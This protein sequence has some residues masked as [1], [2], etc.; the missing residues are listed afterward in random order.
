MT[1][2]INAPKG[3]LTGGGNHVS[4]ICVAGVLLFSPLALTNS[5]AAPGW[6]M[7]P[8]KATPELRQSLSR[9]NLTAGRYVQ[10]TAGS[11]SAEEGRR[12]F[13]RVMGR[14]FPDSVSWLL[15]KPKGNSAKSVPLVVF[16]PGAGELGDDLTRQFHQHAIFERVTS[17]D[18]QS[19]HPC[20]LL[21]L[22]PAPM[23]S[24]YLD[25][26]PGEPSAL[27]DLL[28]GAISAMAST[29]SSPS[30]DKTRIY[31]T[32]LSLG[33]EGVYGLA[34]AFP[35]FF[36][37][38]MPVAAAPP[39]VHYLPKDKPLRFWHFYNDGDYAGRGLDAGVLDD[40]RE[41]I[42]ASGGEFRIGIY[43]AS[44]HNAWDAAWRE[45]AAW[46]WMFAQQSGKKP[47]D[48]VKV[49][50]GRR[51]APADTTSSRPVCTASCPGRDEKSAPERAADG[52]EG[53]AYVSEKPVG[54][55]A[56]LQVEYPNGISGRLLVKTGF[57]DGRNRLMRGRVVT[58]VDGKSWNPCGHVSRETG[59]CS[60][61]L[62]YR[63]RFIRI[64]VDTDVPQAFVVRE[65]AVSE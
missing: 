23:T 44:G 25:G 17:K 56:W 18:F 48:N 29:Y 3:I 30:I 9:Y 41:K 35:N 64:M 14:P 28:V 38:G 40:V 26:E 47:P 27:Q 22:S 62:R 13:Q 43:P 53:T 4:L 16:L 51:D 6:R 39:P 55:G 21:A 42:E 1:A 20:Y 31:A 58:S 33:G 49:I 7:E 32:G 63:V 37:A 10:P 34:I 19:R 5:Q 50:S 59:E 45:E 52:L 60:A 61:T 11:P 65:I 36:A 57:T 24:T 46:D 12:R 8:V 2:N 54:K 15:F